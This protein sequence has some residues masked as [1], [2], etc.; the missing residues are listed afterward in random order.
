V[1]EAK[2]GGGLLGQLPDALT[3]QFIPSVKPFFPVCEAIMKPTSDI[4][5]IRLAV[6][7]G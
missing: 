3:K 5:A 2:S 1:N 4:H 6:A 7:A